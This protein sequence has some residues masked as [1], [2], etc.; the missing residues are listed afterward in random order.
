MEALRALIVSARVKRGWSRARLA[1]A[2]ARW[3]Q[4]DAIELHHVRWLE[5]SCTSPPPP[6]VLVPIVAAL[7]I[8]SNEVLDAMGYRFPTRK[9][10]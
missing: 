8:P 3:A 2:A 1:K 6:S 9:A 4:G 5:R 7:E 10:G